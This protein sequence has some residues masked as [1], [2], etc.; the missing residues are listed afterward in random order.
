MFGFSEVPP[1]M[2]PFPA[3][4]RA[5]YML[6]SMFAIILC[7]RYLSIHRDYVL[8]LVVTA[9]PMLYTERQIKKR[10][11]FM[12]TSEY[13]G[14]RPIICFV[15]S[16]V[17]FLCA[18]SAIWFLF[19]SD[20]SHSG[21][22][23]VYTLTFLETCI[24]F[25]FAASLKSFLLGCGIDIQLLRRG[26]FAIIERVSMLIR[27][28]VVRSKWI[29]F[30]LRDQME[31]MACKVYL[32]L[33][34]IC[35][36]WLV[37]D[38]ATAIHAFAMTSVPVYQCIEESNEKCVICYQELEDPVALK[39]RHVFCRPCIDRWLLNHC[40]CPLCMKKVINFKTVAFKDGSFPMSV[41]LA[42][43]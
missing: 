31:T 28:L 36:I 12:E 20:G 2:I 25:S 43:F 40:T 9:V 27:R 17:V 32:L 33:E 34:F 18:M 37:C 5:N 8:V 30:F 11:A 13:L 38:L 35:N 23:F 24:V 16:L 1:F 10:I 22:C 26:L 41:L 29:S 19:A 4:I 6:C 21:L 3:M 39:C 42:C 7:L 15:Y 14:A